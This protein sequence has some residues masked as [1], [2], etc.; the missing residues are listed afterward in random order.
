MPANTCELSATTCQVEWATPTKKPKNALE[1]MT[2]RNLFSAES[3][4][5]GKFSF[6][7]KVFRIPP[8]NIYCWF[9]VWKSNPCT[10]S[11]ESAPRFDLS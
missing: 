2:T 10:S 1:R 7:S 5:N 4:A 8:Y 6:N 3:L 11:N 9:G